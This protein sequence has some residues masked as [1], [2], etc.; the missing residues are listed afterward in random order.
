[1]VRQRCGRQPVKIADLQWYP[2]KKWGGTCGR[3]RP[4][5][6]LGPRERHCRGRFGV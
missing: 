4:A 6:R 1:M 5:F 2:C 3:G